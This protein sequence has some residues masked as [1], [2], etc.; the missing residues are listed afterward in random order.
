MQEKGLDLI[1]GYKLSEKDMINIFFN[2]EFKE[3]V[4][5]MCKSDKELPK[6]KKMFDA[7]NKT[8][9]INYR[10]I[11][12]F[13]DYHSECF[14]GEDGD[15]SNI[16]VYCTKC[17]MYDKESNWIIGIQICHLPALK[18]EIKMIDTYTISG[19]DENEL[20]RIKH[21][22]NLMVTDCAFYSVPSD[23]WCCT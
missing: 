16:A 13:C 23:C 15:E 11:G 18:N 8:K 10:I 9:N 5:D 6:I 2:K 3:Y 12:L 17:C 7:N 19:H 20:K 1:Y 14:F 21:K 4:L 22:L